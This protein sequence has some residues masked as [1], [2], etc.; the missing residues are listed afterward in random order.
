MIK[1]VNELFNFIE[2]SP[3]VFHNVMLVK[4]I[5]NN[6]N[7]IEL[8]ESEEWV[9]E[10][11][12]N[13]YTIKDFSSI[14]AFKVP[15]SIEGGFN[16][17]ASHNDSPTFKL[18]PN[19]VI[20][21]GK[22]SKMNTEPYGG[23][24]LS[25]FMD[26]PLSVAGRCFVMSNNQIESRLIN[27]SGHDFIIPNVAIHL[28]RGKADNPLNQQTDLL[29]VIGE[30]TSSP[31]FINQ[32]KK[33]AL[34]DEN[35]ELLSYDLFLYNKEKGTT[36]GINH[37]YIASSKL[38]DLECVFCSLESFLESS[39]NN[40]SVCCIFDNEEVGSGSNHAAGSTFLV[41]TLER[42]CQSLNLNH[43]LM[44]AN[45]MLI[46]ADNAHAVHP[47]H[48]ELSDPTNSVYMNKGVVIKYHAGLSY[49]TDALSASIFKSL[50]KKAN[51]PYQDYTNRSDMRGGSTLGHIAL[52]KLSICSCDIGLPQL[53]MHSSFETAG[54]KDLESM[55]KALKEFYNT[56][57]KINYS[58]ISF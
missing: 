43:H 49:T 4:Q 29:P 33:L 20:V 10:P 42:I 16:I 6:Y 15:K 47:A 50:C 35:E 22:Y 41:D 7:F 19:S 14:I 54:S 44:Y 39:G 18:K 1:Y 32:I 56:S 12:K 30:D 11:N 46:S 23:M 58:N 25:T 55:V 36:I 26:R 28:T 27:M 34:L 52:E 40:I 13:Y 5:L 2:N 9:L 53:A 24:I 17:V 21:S 31:D 38:D 48:P 8:K 45:S 3:T 37:E 57:L 51:V